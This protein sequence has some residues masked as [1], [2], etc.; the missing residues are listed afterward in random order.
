VID[1]NGR[2]KWLII[3]I[4]AVSLFLAPVI[5]LAVLTNQPN[6]P[7]NSIYSS[8]H[9]E[10]FQTSATVDEAL[11]RYVNIT[12]SGGSGASG[13]GYSWNTVSGNVTWI[14]S[15]EDSVKSLQNIHLVVYTRVDENSSMS[16]K[17]Y[18]LFIG[19]HVV[20]NQTEPT[21][22]ADALDHQE[23][24]IPT[25]SLDTPQYPFRFNCSTYVNS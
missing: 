4:V 13:P 11:S 14:D 5:A 16:A 7:N 6:P 10:T 3:A 1:V 25:L 20:A 24:V 12:A 9:G 19:I 21:I 8:G 2:T 18:M 23:I 22:P 15:P 17:T